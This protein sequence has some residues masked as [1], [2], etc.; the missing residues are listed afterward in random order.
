MAAS[1][2]KSA[3][4][5]RAFR[6]VQCPAFM[7]ESKADAPRCT[8][9]NNLKRVSA[10]ALATS[11]LLLSPGTSHGLG[12]GRPNSHAVLGDTLSL[13]VP[14]RL[15]PGEEIANDCLAA[16]VYFGD[17]KLPGASVQAVVNPGEG[18][19]RTLKVRTT[20]LINEPVVTVYLAAG[21]KARITRKFVAFADPPGM[22]MPSVAA[23]PA[24]EAPV[25]PASPVAAVVSSKAEKP[26]KSVSV[27]TSAGKA[28]APSTRRSEGSVL[29][30]A[31]SSSL[32][33]PSFTARQARVAP[34]AALTAR[35]YKPAKAAKAKSGAAP[36]PQEDGAR[37]LLDPVEADATVMPNLRM[38]TGFAEL[39]SPD[40][41]SPTTLARRATAAAMWQAMNASPEQLARDR[42]RLQE[43]EQRLAQL[44]QEGEQ[45][46]LA[47]K[48]LQERVQRAEAQRI[49]PQ[50]S[51]ALLAV[52]VGGLAMSAYLYL[53]LRKRR[54]E[55]QDA[56]WKAEA[57]QLHP[58]PDDD[59]TSA[60]GNDDLVAPGL[61]PQS[62]IHARS[63]LVAPPAAAEAAY[64]GEWG[65][66]SL[67]PQQLHAL[68]PDAAPV[69]VPVRAAAAPAEPLR[70]VS[71]EELIDLE[72]QADFFVVLG[73]DA[74]AIELLESHVHS[75]AAASPLPMLKLLEI[76]QRLGQRANYER[77]QSSFNQR[78]NA[79]APAWESDL[80]HGLS[81]SDYPGVVERLQALWQ[82]PTRAMS[83]LETSL[84][85]PETGT[86]TFELPAYRELLFLYAVARDLAEREPLGG[87]ASV[88]LLLPVPDEG[89]LLAA[90]SPDTDMQPLMATLPV[91]AHPDFSPSMSLDLHL[92]DLHAPAA[93]ISGMVLSSPLSSHP[94]EGE[95]PPEASYKP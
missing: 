21:C 48:A 40:D 61:A 11:T 38:A 51:A 93:G 64:G 36:A 20:A 86:E 49:S 59:F 73:Q 9:M 53:Q 77:T 88:D 57:E 79:H 65:E 25:A 69:P 39:A 76:Y 7:L 24:V 81:L 72:Q 33:D 60:L 90:S 27:A 43:L 45:A 83:L 85:R 52:A 82:Q 28:P 84:T 23:S 14:I 47:V 17:D 19:E 29:A 12:F 6:D 10:A 3:Q 34:D 26:L 30:K 94:I 18:A 54:K 75:T 71:V 63:A 37:L 95:Q 13:T 1:R 31:P 78:F 56:W 74:A 50:W 55:E 62:E 80:Q 87:I 8:E 22:S 46:Q 68:V 4:G 91:K 42:Q 67:T 41:N 32:G 66:S 15:E 89:E 58:S 92:D 35:A 2:N 5:L 44:K 70:E 16:D